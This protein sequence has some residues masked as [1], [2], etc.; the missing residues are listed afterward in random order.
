[1]KIL[2]RNER[3]WTNACEKKI[4]NDSKDENKLQTILYLCPL[5]NKYMIENDGK[6][7]C[8]PLMNQRTL[9]HTH[10]TSQKLA[11]IWKFFCYR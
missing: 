8:F 1:M 9:A 5:I 3:R 7:N 4:G 6:G 10:Q 11:Q 2:Y